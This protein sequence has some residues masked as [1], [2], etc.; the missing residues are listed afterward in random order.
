MS[1]GKQL[2]PKKDMLLQRKF[3]EKLCQ[4]WKQVFHFFR[5]RYFRF[6]YYYLIVELRFRYWPIKSN[7]LNYL[8]KIM[9]WTRL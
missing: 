1:C 7:E 3:G 6:C 9:P 4:F 8:I 2:N 5:L